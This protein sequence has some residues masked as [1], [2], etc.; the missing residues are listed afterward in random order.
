MYC[1][2]SGQEVY[3]KDKTC[4]TK[5]ALMR[6]ADT[7]NTSHP[8]DVIRPSKMRDKATLWQALRVKMAS[9]CDNEACWADTLHGHHPSAEV[10]RSLRPIKPKEWDKNSHTWLTNFDIEAVMKQY[11]FDTHPKYKYKFIGV[12]PIDFQ[13]KTLMGQC[14]YREFCSLDIGKLYKQGIRYVGMITNLDK[15]TESG[16]HWT[17][18]FICIDPSLPCFGAYYYDS[19]ASSPP[20]EINVFLE[21]VKYQVMKLPGAAQKTFII[22][23]NNI[24]HQRGN[25]ECGVFSIDYQVRWITSLYKRKKTTFA[26]IVNIPTLNDATIHTH[27]SVYYRPFHQKKVA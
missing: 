2:P 4:F 15:H 20:P 8:N 12:F 22:K 21:S 5:A 25:T 27:R 11:D 18:L 6:L 19:V 14:L 13:A 1:S 10:A 7:W 23:H 9:M 16:S 24:Q 26:D 3:K 17:S